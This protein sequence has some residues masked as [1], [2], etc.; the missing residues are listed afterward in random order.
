VK[1]RER[2]DRDPLYFSRQCLLLERR[3]SLAS[4]SSE[5]PS[6]IVYWTIMGSN[7]GL[8]RQVGA[9]HDRNWHTAG[10][11]S[12]LGNQ[13]I[14]SDFFLIRYIHSKFTIHAASIY[15]VNG[16]WECVGHVWGIVNNICGYVGDKR[17]QKWQRRDFDPKWRIWSIHARYWPWQG[18]EMRRGCME[19]IGWC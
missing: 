19:C 7:N 13:G 12:Q 1:L 6:Q 14:T 9:L 5:R 2:I 10:W 15:I 18:N 17:G 8:I 16:I 4:N 11:L 3:A